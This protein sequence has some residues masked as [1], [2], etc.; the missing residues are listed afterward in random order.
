MG[1]NDETWADAERCDML[2]ADDL[3]KPAHEDIL[4][5]T[6]WTTGHVYFLD[7]ADGFVSARSVPRHPPPIM[8]PATAS[9]IGAAVRYG[10]G[11]Y[12]LIDVRGR[13]ATIGRNSDMWGVSLDDVAVEGERR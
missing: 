10:G 3:A 11:W 2:D 8:R 7:W 12:T 5:F 4:G 6:I 9:D 13:R 1:Y